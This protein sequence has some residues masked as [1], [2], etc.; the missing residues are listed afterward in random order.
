M[1]EEYV[2]NKIIRY[3]SSILLGIFL[4]IL[5]LLMFFIVTITVTINSNRDT[6]NKFSTIKNRAIRGSIISADGYL[7]SYSQKVFRAEVNTRSIDPKKKNLFINL[8]SIYSG[9]SKQE[10]KKKF[11]NRKGKLIRGRIIL[12][13]NINVRLASDLKALSKKMNKMKVFRPLNPKRPHL[14]LG[15]D[16]IAD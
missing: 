10:I 8:F 3:R 11:I 9:M 7:L 5:L 4:V 14:I 2:E 15:L 13:K 16:I 1:E 6:D 12:N